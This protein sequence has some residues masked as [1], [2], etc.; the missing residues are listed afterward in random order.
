[1]ELPDSTR[2]VGCIAEEYFALGQVLVV[3]LVE[4]R[5]ERRVDQT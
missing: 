4:F 3:L 5:L 1:M 2:V